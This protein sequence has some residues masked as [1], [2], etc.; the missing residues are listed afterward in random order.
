MTETVQSAKSIFLRAT[1]SN[2]YKTWRKEAKLS[3]EFYDGD[4]FTDSEISEL[5]SRGQPVIPVNKIAVNLDNIIGQEIRTRPRI[6]FKPRSSDP[7]E[8]LLA[9]A[10]SALALFVQEDQDV[11][12]KLSIRNK[13][14]YIQGIGWIDMDYRSN[15]IEVTRVDPFKVV[16]DIDDTTERLEDSGYVFRWEWVRLEDAVAMFPD[17]E[18]EL[19]KLLVIDKDAS[20]N[21]T[22]AV[23]SLD[24][25]TSNI[26]DDTLFV[27]TPLN[28]I[29]IIEYQYKREKKSYIVTDSSQRT[30]E[31][32]DEKVAKASSDSLEGVDTIVDSN[33]QEVWS[34]FWVAD[35]ELKHEPLF[36]QNGNFTLLPS[37]FKR[38]RDGV[39]YGIVKPAIPVQQELNKR[40]SKA[41]HLMNSR[42]IIMD[43]DA[44]EDLVELA[45]EAARPDGII[46]K[47]Q[48]RELRF[49]D[50][51]RDATQQLS[52]M[53]RAERELDLVMGIFPESLGQTTNATSGIAIQRRQLGSVQNQVRAFDDHRSDRKKFGKDLLTVIQA[54]FTEEQ[55]IEIVDD[56]AL[57]Q[58]IPINQETKVDGKIV[59]LHDVRTAVLD[60]YVEE[61]Q[62]FNAPPE[63]TSALVQGMIQ[64]GQAQFAT[65]PTLLELMGVPPQQ[66]KKIA[67]EMGKILQAAQAAEAPQEGEQEAGQVPVIGGPSPTQ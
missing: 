63:Q 33:G 20:I 66:A 38:N 19:R 50:N 23:L 59:K 42:R 64:N 26:E 62:N 21:A 57:I 22:A 45:D 47:R 53:E 8:G 43:V 54:V 5:T 41:L 3:R 13:D 29:K 58:A 55:M 51:I 11:P 30:F 25:T 7:Q 15:G 52:M 1:N 24:T 14:R 6:G 48:G 18:D 27:D 31:T 56:E 16:W 2:Q 39:F 46:R 60:I 44:V 34:M 61:V 65:S 10:L 36:V 17:K 35:I 40:R 4:Q 67:A 9:E 37:V 49:E 12:Y 28:R 32:F